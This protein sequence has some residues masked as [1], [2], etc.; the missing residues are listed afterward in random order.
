MKFIKK[1]LQ[2]NLFDVRLLSEENYGG[3]T[4]TIRRIKRVW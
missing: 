2:L 3:F 1:W 4:S